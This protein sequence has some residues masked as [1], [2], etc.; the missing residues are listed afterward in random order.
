MAITPAKAARSLSFPADGR[1]VAA[2]LRGESL[3]VDGESGWVLVCVEGFPLGWGKR[4]GGIVKNHYPRGL[5][6]R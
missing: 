4:T 3:R 6:R 1:E 5:R 2:F